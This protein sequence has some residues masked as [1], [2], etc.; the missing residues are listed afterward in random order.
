MLY[1]GRDALTIFYK[2]LDRVTANQAGVYMPFIAPEAKI[3]RTVVISELSI[4]IVDSYFDSTWRD[5]IKC[6]R[7]LVLLSA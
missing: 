6:R 2:N 4:L 3:L 1:F 5:K 7:F